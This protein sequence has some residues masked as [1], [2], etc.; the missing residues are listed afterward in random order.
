MRRF[1]W[2]LGLAVLIAAPVAGATP[3]PKD[4][5]AE[6]Q[7]SG[8]RRAAPT[9]AREAT[10]AE[11]EQQSKALE[12]FEGG[13]TVVIVTSVGTIIIVLLLILLLV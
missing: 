4:A 11:R 2:M 10:Y 6:V 8:A 7:R 13:E 5:P 3:A 12:R 9:A 1:A